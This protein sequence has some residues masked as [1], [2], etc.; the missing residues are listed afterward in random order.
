MH[1][2]AVSA[3]NDFHR[4]FTFR[5]RSRQ[6][7]ISIKWCYRPQS[8]DGMSPRAIRWKLSRNSASRRIGS[9]SHQRTRFFISRQS[10][11]AATWLSKTLSGG[12]SLGLVAS[13]KTGPLACQLSECPLVVAGATFLRTDTRETQG[14][15]SCRPYLATERL[16]ANPR[17]RKGHVFVLLTKLRPWASTTHPLLMNGGDLWQYRSSFPAIDA[18]I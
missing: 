18:S 17:N 16:V 9:W 15:L 4:N 8:L 1:A 2:Y 5:Y 7:T 6:S 14:L 11:T 12:N 13:E 3:H 10:R